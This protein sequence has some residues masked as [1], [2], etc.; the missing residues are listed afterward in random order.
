MILESV[1]KERFGQALGAVYSFGT[2]AELTAPV[3]GGILYDA[4]DILAEFAISMGILIIDLAMRLLVI[5]HDQDEHSIGSGTD[6]IV[7]ENALSSEESKGRTRSTENEP[8]LPEDDEY[9]YKIYGWFCGQMVDKYGTKLIS[10]I[11]YGFLASCLI[12]LGLPSQQPIGENVKVVV[13]CIVLAL[14]GVGL[15]IIKLPGFVEAGD[16]MKKY[17]AANP[18]LF[19]DHGC[20]A[21]LYGFNALFFFSGLTVGP[22]NDSIYI[23]LEQEPSLRPIK[24]LT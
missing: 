12:L 18:T 3:L 7:D 17:E 5:E 23:F 6:T 2:I 4:A 1:G 8:L 21:Q 20:Y 22:L 24:S 11:E 14:D 16:V 9:M 19:G 10:T 15:A 13:Y